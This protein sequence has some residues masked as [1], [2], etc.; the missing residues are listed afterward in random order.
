MG[1]QAPDARSADPQ[2]QTPETIEKMRVAGRLAAQAIQLA[3]EHVQA[4]A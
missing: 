4:R 3:G 2:V 1:K